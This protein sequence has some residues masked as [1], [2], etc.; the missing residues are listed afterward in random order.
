MDLGGQAQEYQYQQTNQSDHDSTKPDL[1]PVQVEWQAS[2][3]IDHQK[4]LVWFLALGAAAVVGSLLMFL[5]TRSYNS[6]AVVLVCIFVFAIIAK[7]KPRTLHYA[8]RGHTLQIGEKSYNYDDFRSFS[9][10]HETGLPSI[11]LQPIKR[12]IPII[13]IYFAPDDGEK[14]FDAFAEHL[15]NEQRKDDTVEQLMRKIR[16]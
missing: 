6:T 2:E 1:S 4:S 8:L 3:F 9:V 15:P 10:N 7:Q 13:T 14:I 16:F 12:F 5:I 11:T